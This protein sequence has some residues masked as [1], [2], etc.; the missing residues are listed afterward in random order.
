MKDMS[1]GGKM[2]R[3]YR[4]LIFTIT[5]LFLC[6]TQMPATHAQ[7]GNLA[8]T[9]NIYTYPKPFKA[10]NMVLQNLYGQRVSLNDYKGKVVLLHFWKI[11]CPACKIEKP[12]LQWLKK[13]Y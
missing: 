4:L 11:Q 3:P 8:S 12:L 2:I 1:C 6:T 13:N 7:S 9:S 10:S 5:L